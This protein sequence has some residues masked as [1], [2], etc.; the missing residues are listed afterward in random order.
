MT[1]HRK[2]KPQNIISEMLRMLDLSVAFGWRWLMICFYLLTCHTSFIFQLTDRRNL[3]SKRVSHPL[4]SHLYFKTKWINL[5]TYQIMHHSVSFS[6]RITRNIIQIKQLR[7][8]VVAAVNWTWWH[9]HGQGRFYLRRKKY[10]N[11]RSLSLYPIMNNYLKY[12]WY[13]H[14][15]IFIF[16]YRFIIHTTTLRLK[17][18]LIL[19]THIVWNSN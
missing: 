11:F 14:H 3:T 4:V 17:S 15:M 10:V 6:H 16:F 19:F 5:F 1:S 8:V 7:L 12:T 9:Y 18:I 2:Q 13:T